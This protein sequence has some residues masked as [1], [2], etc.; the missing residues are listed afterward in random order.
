MKSNGVLE[1]IDFAILAASEEVVITG[2]LDPIAAEAFD[3]V[4]ATTI[5]VKIAI[6]KAWVMAR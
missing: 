3:G 4:D 2:I 1:P 6:T 5:P